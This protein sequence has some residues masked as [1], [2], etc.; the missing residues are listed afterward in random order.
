M[1]ST[2]I[3]QMGR[4]RGNSGKKLDITKY[5]KTNLSGPSHMVEGIEPAF[6]RNENNK[7]QNYTEALTITLAS[8]L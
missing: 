5:C 4:R 8:S 1:S 2:L 6:Q 7:P 3:G